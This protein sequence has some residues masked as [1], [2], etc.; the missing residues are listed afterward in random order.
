[1]KKRIY[2]GGV[3]RVHGKDCCAANINGVFEGFV[4]ADNKEELKAKF[5]G[6]GYAKHG[7][8]FKV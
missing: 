1:M 6:S 5:K 2:N 8:L 3:N 4:K 7:V